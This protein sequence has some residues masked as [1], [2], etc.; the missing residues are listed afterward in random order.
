MNKLFDPS[1]FSGPD[2]FKPKNIGP[3][4]PVTLTKLITRDSGSRRIN[5]LKT[6]LKMFED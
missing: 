4:L 6:N 5:H 2:I 1:P 3:N